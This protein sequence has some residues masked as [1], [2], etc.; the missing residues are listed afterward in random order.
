MNIPLPQA[1]P[2]IGLTE[3]SYFELNDDLKCHACEIFMEKIRELLDEVDVK[4]RIKIGHRLKTGQM[5]GGDGNYIKFAR[6]ETR[7]A[8]ILEELCGKVEWKDDAVVDAKGEKNLRIYKRIRKGN[9]AL[10]RTCDRL[11]EEHEDYISELLY[12]NF[13]KDLQL[14]EK[15]CVK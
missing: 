2:E 7:I 1:M 8:E 15:I 5:G 12:D 10:R 4:K 9:A 13:D 6:S 14:K 11:I 3:N